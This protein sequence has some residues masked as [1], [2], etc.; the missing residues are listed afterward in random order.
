VPALSADA[1]WWERLWRRVRAAPPV[2]WADRRW[3][4]EQLP[5]GHPDGRYGLVEQDDTR[6]LLREFGDALD[7]AQGDMEPA[8]AALDR[9][10][11]HVGMELRR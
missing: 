2:P 3:E 11:A 1:I 8:P 7:A 9:L 5:P 6:R 10:A 4:W